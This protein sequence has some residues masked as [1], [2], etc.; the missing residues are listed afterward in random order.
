MPKIRRW[1]P[2]SHD[3]NRDPQIIT[4]R[5][6]FGDWAALAWLECLSIADRN[7]GLV[8][9][10]LDEIASRLAP[11]SLQMY[12]RRAQ[13]AA[14]TMLE[15]FTDNSWTREE[16]GGIRILKY[17]EYHRRREPIQHPSETN[18]TLLTT[19]EK[20]K[21]RNLEQKPLIWPCPELLIEKYN[22]ETPDCLPAV[23]K[24]TPARLRKAREY[25][26]IFPDES[27]WTEV[28]AEI[29]K[30]DF[31]QG[32]KNTN[33]HGAFKANFD[34]ILTKGKDQTENVVKVFEGRYN[35]GR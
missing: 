11:V 23:E 21:I 31:L 19:K 6:D 3:F 2:T 10:T 7:D 33:G 17:W 26:K 14:R 27:F 25:L 30:S 16:P 20:I 1:H 4:L 24:I 5:K 35:N 12:H 32:L 8:P 13:N 18:D 15:R 29:G 34:W 22:R 28:F 9:G